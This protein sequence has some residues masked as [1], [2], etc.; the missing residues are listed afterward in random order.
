MGAVACIGPDRIM[1]SSYGLASCIIRK[2][3]IA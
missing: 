3:S 1:H 2:E